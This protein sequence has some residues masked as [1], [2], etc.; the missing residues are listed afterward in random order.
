MNILD[1]KHVFR[2]MLVYVQ[3]KAAARCFSLLHV[4]RRNV[5]LLQ[6]T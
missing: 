6:E 3:I 2:P 1:V 4:N 5:L